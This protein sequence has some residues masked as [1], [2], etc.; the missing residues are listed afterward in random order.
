MLVNEHDNTRQ[1]K[2]EVLNARKPVL[3]HGPKPPAA[4]N[5]HEWA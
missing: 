4:D 1:E 2:I 5:A 3:K